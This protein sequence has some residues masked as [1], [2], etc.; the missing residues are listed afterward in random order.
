MF[1]AVVSA[2]ID[3]RIT[4]GEITDVALKIIFPFHLSPPPPFAVAT[5]NTVTSSITL[6]T[7]FTLPTTVTLPTAVTLSTAFSAS[8]T[9]FASVFAETAVN[10][11][12]VAVVV[13][14][15]VVAVP[16]AQCVRGNNL[17][18]SRDFIIG[19]LY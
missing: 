2:A 16:I 10:F 11:Y 17:T 6:S 14:A 7:A 18:Y 5:A 1:V 19:C 3:P 12:V 4:A 8:A 9:A 15:V 13:S